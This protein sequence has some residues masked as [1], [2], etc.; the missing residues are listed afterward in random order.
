MIIEWSLLILDQT[1]PEL[2]DM[3]SIYMFRESE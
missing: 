2:K 3:L 1:T